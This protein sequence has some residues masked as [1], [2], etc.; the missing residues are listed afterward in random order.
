MS[1]RSRALLARFDPH[2]TVV[3]VLRLLAATVCFTVAGA[4]LLV[5]ALAASFSNGLPPGVFAFGAIVVGASGLGAMV[6]P[7]GEDQAPDPPDPP[8]WDTVAG[9]PIASP[10]SADGPAV[11]WDEWAVEFER[12]YHEE[13]GWRPPVD[14]LR[15][16]VSPPPEGGDHG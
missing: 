8:P 13:T 16:P 14:D 15:R 5:V 7:R 3:Y 9:R 12:L 1:R 2:G 6:R 4:A 11:N 10:A